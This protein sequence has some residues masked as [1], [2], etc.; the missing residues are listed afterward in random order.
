MNSKVI[1]LI[2]GLVV[3]GFAGYVTR[4]NSAE[5]KIG[6]LS[7]EV[8]TDQPAASGSPVTNSQWQRI[9]IFAVIGALVGLAIGFTVDRRRGI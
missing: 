2:I 9:G 1:L 4:P 5:I 7:M 6:P 8:T 3:G